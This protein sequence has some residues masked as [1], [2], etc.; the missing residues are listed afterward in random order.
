MA[1]A[2]KSPPANA[3]D[4]KR[5][6]FD[7]WV[8]KIPW[9]RKWQPTPV[10]FPGKSH[11]PRSLAG[12][13]PWGLKRAGQNINHLSVSCKHDPCSFLKNASPPSL[14]GDSYM[15]CCTIFCVLV[16][17]TQIF[18]LFSSDTVSRHLHF[19]SLSSELVNVYQCTSYM[20]P[21]TQHNR[22]AGFSPHWDYHLL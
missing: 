20:M 5:Y 2:V 1:L 14:S 16:K 19:W 7:P 8:G 13:S 12:Y 9:R 10:L 22:W 11:G 18:L 6:R 21:R 15:A 17:Y 4:I 3:G